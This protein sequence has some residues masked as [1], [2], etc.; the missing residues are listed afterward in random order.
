METKN[1]KKIYY[2]DKKFCPYWS[3]CQTGDDCKHALTDHV[4]K[5]AF[6]F[7]LPIDQYENLPSDC[8]SIKA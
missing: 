3:S 8:Y 1:V 4:I 5:E 7:H 6:H 2:K